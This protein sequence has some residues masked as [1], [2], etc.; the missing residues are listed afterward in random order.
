MRVR[1]LGS[2]GLFVDAGIGFL[3][4]LLAEVDADQVVLEDVVVEHIFGGF[5]E[6]DDPLGHGRRADAERHVLG[7]GR[8]G[9]VIVAADP[10]DPAG[11]EVGVARVFAFHEDAVAAEDRRGAVALGDRPLGEIDLGVDAQAAHDPRDRVPGHID[12]VGR[13]ERA[14][15][16]SVRVAVAMGR[17]LSHLAV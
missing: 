10:A 1:R 7:V 3:D 11:D 15:P 12:Q 8:A 2:L 13:T 5:S 4:H 14:I 17:V 6:V 9:G 16:F